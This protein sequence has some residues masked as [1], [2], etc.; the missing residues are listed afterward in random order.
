MHILLRL[1]RLRRRA[2]PLGGRLLH[3]LL[4]RHCSLSPKPGERHKC[5][6]LRAKSGA[7]RRRR[8]FGRDRWRFPARSLIPCCRTARAASEQWGGTRQNSTA[9]AKFSLPSHFEFNFECQGFFIACRVAFG[10]N[11][12]AWIPIHCG[13]LGVHIEIS[14]KTKPMLITLRHL[15]Y[16]PSLM[17]GLDVAVV[18]AALSLR[19]LH[20]GQ[21]LLV[22]WDIGVLA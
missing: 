21:A 18:T 15:R 11:P 8:Q 14:G 6:R 5:M 19:Y 2:S 20:L 9:N 22:G 4:L 17:T 1:Q 3:V 7:K 13:M 10:T 16:R 12:F